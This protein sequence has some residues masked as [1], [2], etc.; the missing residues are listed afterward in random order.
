MCDLELGYEHFFK[1]LISAFE[2]QR[3]RAN[4][5]TVLLKKCGICAGV[6]IYFFY[7]AIST[8]FSIS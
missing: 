2:A 1:I 3:S 7:L 5:F 8:F 6:F 4:F